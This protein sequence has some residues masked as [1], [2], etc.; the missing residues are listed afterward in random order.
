MNSVMSVVLVLVI[1]ALVGIGVVATVRTILPPIEHSGTSGWVGTA[2]RADET[3]YVA[4]PRLFAPDRQGF[5]SV[6][7][8]VSLVALL[9]ASTAFAAYTIRLAYRDEPHARRA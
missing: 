6:V 7:S 2:P 5:L 8:G 1:L 9:V 4:L 3:G